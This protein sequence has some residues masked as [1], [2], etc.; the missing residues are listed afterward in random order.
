ME[1][2]ELTFTGVS[3]VEGEKIGEDIVIHEIAHSWFGNLVTCGNWS[4]FW[5]NEGFT[6]FMSYKVT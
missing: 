3:L 6:T 1:N 2:P 4:N 5:I